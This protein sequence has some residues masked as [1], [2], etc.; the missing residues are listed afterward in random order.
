MKRNL[1]ATAL[2]VGFLS[3]TLPMTSAKEAQSAKS[4]PYSV[5]VHEFEGCECE[6]VCPCVFSQ[7]TTYGECKA[8]LVFTFDGTYG[9]TV[10]NKV[11]C[12]MVGT[13]LGRNIEQ[14][15][16]NWEGVLYTSSSA[17]PDEKAAVKGLLHAMMGDAFSSLDER[18]ESI[19][20]K[21]AGDVHELTLGEIAHL[22]VHAIKGPDGKATKIVNAPSPIAFREF[23]CAIADENRYDDGVSSWSFAG[24]NGFYTTFDLA[25][26]D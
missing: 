4:V 16:G 1:A 24:R 8:I 12:V 2:V 18:K 13:K 10:L 11:P 17:T 26:A 9:S 22:K 19:A 15:I 7:D 21:V 6:S 25:S 14:N 20:I 3:T 23:Y 5:K